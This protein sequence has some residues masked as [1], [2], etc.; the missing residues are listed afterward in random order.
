MALN[1]PHDIYYNLISEK[2]ENIEKKIRNDID[3]S[4]LM[5]FDS[6]TKEVT[7][8][9][10][11][12]KQKL[13]NV[14]K[15]YAMYDKEVNYCQGTNFIVAVLV[16]NIASERCVF[17][18]FF[19]LMNEKNWRTLCLNKI[20]KLLRMLDLFADQLQLKLYEM[21]QYFDSIGVIYSQ[22]CRY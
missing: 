1:H 7:S 3:R 20:P 11:K 22:I 12:D 18:T 19:Q 8:F 6:V 2:D 10:I 16:N 13:Y 9:Q 4:A 14:L 17:W 5:T 15:A 21:Y